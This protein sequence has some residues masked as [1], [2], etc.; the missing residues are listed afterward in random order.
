[1]RANWFHENRRV[2]IRDREARNYWWGHMDGEADVFGSVDGWLVSSWV[3]SMVASN[4][5]I[6]GVWVIDRVGMART[7]IHICRASSG[8]FGRR[9]DSRKDCVFATAYFL[10]LILTFLFGLL[11]FVLGYF[12][13][14]VSG[15]VVYYRFWMSI[16]HE[17]HLSA[18]SSTGY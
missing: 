5:G 10:R 7:E 11:R 14:R 4:L 12:S 15:L 16:F 17:K 13:L 3:A 9:F 6:C 8:F 18:P 1:M 2:R